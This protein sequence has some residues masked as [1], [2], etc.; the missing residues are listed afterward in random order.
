MSG[1]RPF[2]LYPSLLPDVA[3]PFDRPTKSIMPASSHIRL[4]CGEAHGYCPVK[5]RRGVSGVNRAI[6][7]SGK[8]MANRRMVAVCAVLLV[9]VLASARGYSAD[10]VLIRS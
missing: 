3:Q 9:V 5:S 7:E 6:T 2:P 10:V 8:H 1:Y 4:W